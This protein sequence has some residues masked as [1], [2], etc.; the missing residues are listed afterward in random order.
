MSFRRD[1]NKLQVAGQAE[2]VPVGPRMQE[3]AGKKTTRNIKICDTVAVSGRGCLHNPGLSRGFVDFFL[4]TPQP[5][6]TVFLEQA[7]P[8]KNTTN[9][10]NN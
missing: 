9:S 10:R 4:I 7:A 3:V 8:V 5:H 6:T 2:E 1:Q